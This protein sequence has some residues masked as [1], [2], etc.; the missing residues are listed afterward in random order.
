MI[1]GS[2]ILMKKTARKIAVLVLV[3]A[4]IASICM[5]AFASKP[6]VKLVSRPTTVRRGYY[7]RHKYYLNSNSYSYKNGY[8]ARFETQ[9]FKRS[10][11]KNYGG[12]GMNWSGRGY[13]TIK[14]A[15]STDVPKGSYRT[16]VKTYY[17]SSASYNRWTFVRSFNWYFNIK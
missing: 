17:R 6:S 9:Y 16:C 10:T 5:P 2:V 13:Q 12:T 1:E 7:M 11:G 3:M 4:L 14:T 15:V 8:R